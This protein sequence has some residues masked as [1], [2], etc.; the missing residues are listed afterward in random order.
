MVL[1]SF[2]VRTHSHS[3]ERVIQGRTKWSTQSCYEIDHI[4]VAIAGKSQII[5]HLW[6]TPL[7]T[8]STAGHIT[9]SGTIEQ[10]VRARSSKV[11]AS[12]IRGRSLI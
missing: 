10:Q 8:L 2:N 9:K 11:T 7:S 12:H 6:W 4:L 3:F 1:L 5:Q